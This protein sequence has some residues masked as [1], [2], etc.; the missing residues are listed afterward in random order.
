MNVHTCIYHF[1]GYACVL[2]AWRSSQCHNSYQTAIIMWLYL[3]CEHDTQCI[4]NF[5]LMAVQ[6]QF[7]NKCS[8]YITLSV[9]HLFDHLPL[10]VI[11]FTQMAMQI[12]F[13]SNCL[14]HI[15]LN[16]DLLLDCFT[17]NAWVGACD[18]C[19]YCPLWLLAMSKCI[20]SSLTYSSPW[21]FY[22]KLY[23]RH[24]WVHVTPAFLLAR[25]GHVTYRLTTII[26]NL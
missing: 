8:F 3:V 25:R 13:M 17:P 18:F 6:I 14:F 15:N 2:I 23:Y 20:S 5:T 1:A 12:P 10:I 11:T 22:F 7:T 24:V 9:D 4:L 16:V 26:Q 19:L 21:Q